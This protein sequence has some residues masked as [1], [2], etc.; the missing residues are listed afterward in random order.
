LTQAV[1]R[2]CEPNKHHLSGKARIKTLEESSASGLYDCASRSY[3]PNSKDAERVS[4]GGNG[5]PSD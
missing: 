1:L 3:G 2:D 4:M 5:P